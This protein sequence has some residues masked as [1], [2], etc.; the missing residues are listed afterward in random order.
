[1]NLI[2]KLKQLG[3][4]IEEITGWIGSGGRVVDRAIAQDRANVCQSCPHNKAVG[5]AKN[6]VAGVARKILEKKNRAGLRVSGEKSLG[7][8]GLCGCVLRLLVWEEQSRIEPFMS[9]EDKARTPS[10]CWKLRKP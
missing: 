6:S 4:G 7:Q 3:E 8:C 9:A 1:M 5:G 2:E 10:H